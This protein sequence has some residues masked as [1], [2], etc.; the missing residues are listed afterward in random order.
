MGLFVFFSLL[1]KGNFIFGFLN[2][3]ITHTLGSNSYKQNGVFLIFG[4]REW[5]WLKPFFYSWS[6]DYYDNNFSSF[7]IE[8]VSQRKNYDIGLL[9]KYLPDSSKYESISFGGEVTF[10]SSFSHKKISDFKPQKRSN[11][12]LNQVDIGINLI[13]TT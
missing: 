5:W 1:V 7:S 10:S 3:N 11:F 12:G 9:I 4:K 8:W 2:T 6:N 13:F